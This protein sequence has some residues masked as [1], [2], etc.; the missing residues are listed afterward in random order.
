MVVS[1]NDP[2]AVVEL[3]FLSIISTAEVVNTPLPSIAAHFPFSILNASQIELPSALQHYLCS[4]IQYHCL[5]I[6]VCFSC[7]FE[8]STN[9]IVEKQKHVSSL[10]TGL[11]VCNSF[12]N[13]FFLDLS[14]A[15]F[16]M[17]LLQTVLSETCTSL[18]SLLICILEYMHDFSKYTRTCSTLYTVV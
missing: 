6:E 2:R 1:C 15:L 9:I 7:L 3:G 16:Q 5:I 12:K 11:K 14:N 18:L 4:F 17:C 13:S 10:L 8:C